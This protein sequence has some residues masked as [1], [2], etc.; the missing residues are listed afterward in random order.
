V[1]ARLFDGP[2]QS[3]PQRVIRKGANCTSKAL[4]GRSAACT[5]LCAIAVVPLVLRSATKIPLIAIA[6][7]APIV[8]M[9]NMR[10]HLATQLKIESAKIAPLVSWDN[11]KKHL[12]EQLQIE[13]AQTARFVSTRST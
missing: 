5:F 11:I 12:V 1:H 13:L 3:T 2:S 10:F 8:S 7:I 9:A 6:I 4:L